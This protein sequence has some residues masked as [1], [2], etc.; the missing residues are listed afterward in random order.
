MEFEIGLEVRHK[1]GGSKMIVI[2][3]GN[4]NVRASWMDG[5]TY[6][7]ETF[8]EEELEGYV[9]ETVSFSQQM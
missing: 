9:S 4:G 8:I 6:R 5:T 1:T 7:K 2:G 3:I